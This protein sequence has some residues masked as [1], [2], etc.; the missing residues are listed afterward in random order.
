MTPGF[1]W[2]VGASIL[3]AI[4]WLSFLILWLFFYA[5]AYNIF[6]NLAIV[7]V[8]VLAS[9]GLL[10]AMWAPWGMRMAKTAG[11][12]Q[13]CEPDRP[14]LMTVISVATGVGWLIFLMIWLFFY[15]GEYNGYQNIAVFI[16]S[17]VVVGIVNGGGW[18]LWSMMR[19]RRWF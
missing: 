11:V 18:A 13:K 9:V 19:G 5:S 3:I 8:S 10:G 6:Q 2:R 14:I 7:I 16:L 17:L 12:S 4:G 15:A 1:G